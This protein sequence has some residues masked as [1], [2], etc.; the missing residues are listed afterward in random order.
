MSSSQVA[1]F[2]WKPPQ[3]RQRSDWCVSACLRNPLRQS[4]HGSP[5]SAK[6]HHCLSGNYFKF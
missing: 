3:R 1:F 6:R 4:V 2:D 5:S